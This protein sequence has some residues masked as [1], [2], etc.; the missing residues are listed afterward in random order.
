MSNSSTQ[1][2]RQ[3]LSEHLCLFFFST[4]KEKN[5]EPK[6]FKHFYSLITSKQHDT[7]KKKLWAKEQLLK[8]FDIPDLEGTLTFNLPKIKSKH[9]QKEGHPYA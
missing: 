4:T 7:E 8:C 6:T 9:K 5:L 1:Q 2:E 3:T